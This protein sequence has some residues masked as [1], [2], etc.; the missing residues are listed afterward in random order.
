MRVRKK[1]KVYERKRKALAK[2]RVK[3]RVRRKK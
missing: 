1:R 3:K 2:L